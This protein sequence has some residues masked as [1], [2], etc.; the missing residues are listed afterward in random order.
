[1]QQGRL[2]LSEDEIEFLRHTIVTWLM[3]KSED[4]VYSLLTR[5][6]IEVLET[7][8][9]RLSERLDNYGQANY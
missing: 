6:E 5:D 4:V 9:V 1:M 3:T 2:N 8:I 7:R